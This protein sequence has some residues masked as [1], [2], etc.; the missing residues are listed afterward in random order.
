M[1]LDF[2]EEGYYEL[3]ACVDGVNADKFPAD[4]SIG[5]MIVKK[6]DHFK[7]KMAPGGGFLL[8]MLKK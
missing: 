2:P 6:G 3:T 4:Y 7:I 8:R 1:L 5:T